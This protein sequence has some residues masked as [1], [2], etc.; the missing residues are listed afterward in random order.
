MYCRNAWV[1]VSHIMILLSLFFF[2]IVDVHVYKLESK[3]IKFGQTFCSFKLSLIYLPL[4]ALKAFF[5]CEF[6]VR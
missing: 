4:I 3:Q 5:S 6:F 2:I 1:N